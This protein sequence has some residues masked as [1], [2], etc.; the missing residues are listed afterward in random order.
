MESGDR[1]FQSSRGKIVECLKRA[2]G[3]GARDLAATLGLTPNAVRQQ[4]AALSAEGLVRAEPTRRGPTKPTLLYRL[5]EKGERLFPQRNDQ[6]LHLVLSE[7]AQEGGSDR[8]VEL[9]RSIGRRSAEKFRTRL[10]G[11]DFSGK[12]EELTAILREQGVIA[13]VERSADG[14]MVLREHTCPFSTS[15]KHHPQVCTLIH[16]VMEELIPGEHTQE[17]SL[18][19]GDRECRFELREHATEPGIGPVRVGRS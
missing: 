5:T 18:A 12:V 16:T 6:L 4:L 1:F 3:A 14:T 2:G 19:K 13:D 7:L 17:T 15:V 10:E 8:V 11:K 9:F